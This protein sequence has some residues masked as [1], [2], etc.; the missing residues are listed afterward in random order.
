MTHPAELSLHQFMTDAV[1]GKTTMPKDVIRQVGRD[2]T[3]ALKRQFSSGIS[4]D[5]FSLRMSNI[6]RPTCQLW[7]QKNKP[8]LAEPKPTNF[9]MNMLLG[10]IVEAVF[11]GLLKAAGVEYTDSLLTLNYLTSKARAFL[12]D[13]QLNYSFVSSTKNRTVYRML[14]LIQ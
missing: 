2:V 9:L 6:G 7:F 5:K 3:A 13:K 14:F 12:L 8:E 4:R 10:D 11:K 1:K